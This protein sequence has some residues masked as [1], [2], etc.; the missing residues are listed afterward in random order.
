[1]ATVL[2]AYYSRKGENYWD[3]Q[4][5]SLAKGNTEIIAAMIQKTIGGDLF[6]ID[7]VKSYPEDYTA[8]T[9]VAQEELRK[10]A[11]PKLKN[12][13]KAWMRMIPFCGISEL[14]GNLSDGCFYIFR[15]L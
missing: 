12:I 10:N 5:V 11:R 1:M 7:T 14:V 3:G 2:I 4:I 6:E 13:W 8:C 15:T 9:K